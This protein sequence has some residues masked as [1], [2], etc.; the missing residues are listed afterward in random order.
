MR[1]EQRC[2]Y[3]AKS[4]VIGSVAVQHVSAF[5]DDN[6]FGVP[7]SLKTL[8]VASERRQVLNESRIAQDLATLSMPSDDPG[9]QALRKGHRKN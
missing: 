5:G 4:D 6:I 9:L 2:H 8:P 7:M 3:S 1:S